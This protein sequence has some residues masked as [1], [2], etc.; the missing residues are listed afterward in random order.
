MDPSRFEGVTRSEVPRERPAEAVRIWLL[1]GF[2]V[3]VGT[4]TIQQNEWRLRKAASL[5]KLLALAPGHR[6]HR[7]QAMDLLWPDLGRKA[8]SNNLR[9]VLHTARRVLDPAPASPNRYLSLQNE[10]I[11]LCPGGPLW[12]DVEAFEEAAAT[13]R[14]SHD[15]AAYRATIE[16]YAGHLLPEDRY[17]EWA[18]GRREEPRRTFLSLL[19][20][21]ARIYEQRGKYKSGIEALRKVVA[22][23]PTNQEAHVGLM[24]LYS[25][26][27][28]QAEALAQYKR[29]EESL[30]RELGAEPNASSRALREEIVAGRFPPPDRPVDPPERGSSDPPRHNLPAPQTSFVGREREMVKVKR[31]L[32]MT[33]LLTLTGAGGS[34]KTRLALE[35]ARD[36]VGAYQ[37]GVWLVE[38]AELSDAEL[39]PQVVA[40]DLGVKER[41]GEPLTELESVVSVKSRRPRA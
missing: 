15:P 31:E 36:L 27:R 10:Q 4:R 32:A 28:M 5:V 2:R 35:V 3:S 22:E 18:D 34:G 17:E 26:S 33:R 9:R 30:S 13:A 21:L 11:T 14:R 7:E 40:G 24:R 39:V 19:V 29:L 12:V 20:E 25:L 37:D 41:P 23:E 6:L 1:G 38:L 8:A 16:L